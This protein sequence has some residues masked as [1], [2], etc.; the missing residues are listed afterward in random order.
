MFR[1]KSKPEFQ[2]LYGKNN[3]KW[4]TEQIDK[5]IKQKRV[6]EIG[7]ST[8]E[9]TATNQTMCQICYR[10]YEHLNATTCCHSAV[11]TECFCVISS[12]LPSQ[13][14]CPFCRKT[15]DLT[16]DGEQTVAKDGDDEA[17]VQFEERR[18][19]GL[20]DSCSYKLDT[21]QKAIV[22][23]I[24]ATTGASYFA[25]RELVVA[26]IPEEDILMQFG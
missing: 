17:F 10:Y 24:V 14:P 18:K 21:A 16:P 6:S 19:Q 3:Y 12:K 1:K 7:K 8:E 5:L 11:C 20:E 9:K 15:L 2:G 22:E 25:I 26:G 13:E 23:R 4:T